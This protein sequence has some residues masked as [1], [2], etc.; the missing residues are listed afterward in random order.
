MQYLWCSVKQCFCAM[1]RSH[2]Q[3]R[4]GV[5]ASSTASTRRALPAPPHPSSCGERERSLHHST[6]TFHDSYSNPLPP[7]NL[8]DPGTQ[9]P[10]ARYS[11]TSSIMSDG[12][13]SAMTNRSLRAIRTVRTPVQLASTSLTRRCR[14]SNFSLTLMS[15]LHNNSTQLQAN[16]HPLPRPRV[17]SNL[18]PPSRL[19]PC[20]R[21]LP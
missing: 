8:V 4:S 12:L 5:C 10:I 21:W 6:T 13:S 3:E 14:N 19:L 15:L 20:N 1:F 9:S 17:T 18:P 2:A 11:R 7:F 16:F